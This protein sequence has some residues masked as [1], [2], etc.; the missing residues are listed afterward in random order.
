MK[1]I[2][3]KYNRLIV[4]PVCAFALLINS[5]KTSS[6]KAVNEGIIEYEAKVVDFN[7]PLAE[8]APGA[9]T[10]KFKDDKMGMEMTAMGMFKN[11]YICNLSKETLTQMVNF[12]DVKQASI[13]DK[14]EIEKENEDYKLIFEETPETKVIAGYTCKRIK[15]KK[16]KDPSTTFDAYYTSEM[17]P[18]DINSLSP[19]SEIKGMLMQYRLSKMGLEMEFTAKSVKK[20]E[21]PDETFV[22]PN[23]FKVISKQEMRKFFDQ[24]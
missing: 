13:D 20:A 14:K 16:A 24:F 12:L 22:V 7:H 23:N 19:Y 4:F 15:V 9:A 8:L 10:L 2:R 3:V 11:T 17:G 21:I 18:D 6:E 5:C 1:N